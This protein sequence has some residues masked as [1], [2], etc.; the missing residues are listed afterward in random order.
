MFSD[1]FLGASY[2][3]ACIEPYEA[4]NSVLK[5]S[6]KAVRHSKDML[7]L[8]P[9]TLTEPKTLNPTRQPF[10]KAP[11]YRTGAL[12]STCRIGGLSK[13]VIK[14]AKSTLGSEVGLGY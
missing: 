5:A 6:Y 1:G 10:P 3:K 11:K 8:L 7:K 13:W 2:P 9:S 14:T 4:C 12:N